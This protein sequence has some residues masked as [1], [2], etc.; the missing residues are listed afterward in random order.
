VRSS[1]EPSSSIGRSDCEVKAEPT[2]AVVGNGLF[3]SAAAR[4]L[5]EAAQNR[6]ATRAGAT[7]VTDTVTA[8]EHRSSLYRIA[9]A[10]GDPV[11]ADLALLAAGTFCN[12]NNLLPSPKSFL[13][14]LVG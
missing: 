11:T 14:L 8:I 4:H 2:V 7:L 12:F 3:G 6:L 13:T 1:T 5:A 10:A 9:T